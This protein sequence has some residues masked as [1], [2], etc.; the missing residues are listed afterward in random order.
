MRW[1][2]PRGGR[3]NRALALVI[4]AA[5]VL[6][7]LPAGPLPALG[8]DTERGGPDPAGGFVDPVS[9]SA[10]VDRS[11]VPA[12]DTFEL[13]V[14]AAVIS[15]WH[16]NAHKPLEDF[17]IGTELFVDAPELVEVVEVVYPAEKREKFEFSDELM[18]VYDGRAPVKA[19]LRI[20]PGVAPG[21]VSLGG[22]LYYQACDDRVCLAPDEKPYQVEITVTE[23]EGAAGAA[24]ADEGEAGSVKSRLTDSLARNF[25]NP[26]IAVLLTLLAGL[27]SAATPCV[28]PMIPITA[29]ILMGRGGDNPALG[30]MHAFMYFL[31]IIVIYAVL[32]FIAGM[33]GGGFNEILRIPFVILMFAILFALLGLSMLGFFEIQIPQSLAARV[34]SSTSRRTGL[35]GTLLMGAGAGLVVSPCVGP[36]VIFILTQIAHQIAAVEAAGGGFSATTKIL[37]GSYLMAGYGAG[38]GVPFLVVGLFSARLAQPGGWMTLVRVVLGL[39]I[40]YF[41]YD[42]FH[43]AMAT[44]GVERV[45]ASSILAGVILIFLSVLWG[46]FRTR[47][48][49]DQHAGWHKVRL[50]CTIIMLVT[51]VF[52]LW[53]G[54]SRSGILP[55]G[56]VAGYF[57]GAGGP[58]GAA[59]E[60]VETTGNLVWQR[61]FARAQEMARQDGLPIFI[62]FYAHWCANCKKF[63]HLAAQ[64]GP[65]NA[66]LQKVVLAKVYDTDEVFPT[67]KNDPRY[68]ELKRGLPFFLI[69]S[70]SGEYLWKGA[71]YRDHDTMIAQIDEALGR[72]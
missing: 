53:T 37:Y 2:E 18:A 7:T 21:T 44:A 50:A 30:R 40:L 6:V 72:G 62:D 16:I 20:K 12:G 36:V 31:G 67:F 70:S 41:A 10:R 65:L 63:N 9:V 34:D 29:R 13:I 61:D 59:I 24:A 57:S 17:L 28:Y 45:F 23:G 32:G 14:T 22:T 55:G 15:G 11:E 69:L 71:D 56:Q 46:V 68:P 27:L 52:F 64:E 47:I 49:D 60:T 19:T 58:G 4:G 43:K 1:E 51:G 66:A 54:L 38:L 26:L 35:V 25:G 8:I 48:E 33:T 5:L 39:V 42:Y 3:C